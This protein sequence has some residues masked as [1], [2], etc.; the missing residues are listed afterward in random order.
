MLIRKILFLGLGHYAGH[1][2]LP[3][4]GEDQ[5]VVE[6]NKDRSNKIFSISRKKILQSLFSQF[7]NLSLKN[8]AVAF[9][10]DE[11][12]RIFTIHLADKADSI[13]NHKQVELDPDLF[14]I[15][16]AD[17]DEIQLSLSCGL[18]FNKLSSDNF[19]IHLLLTL[20][21]EPPR[22]F[23]AA[24]KIYM[25]PRTS[26]TLVGF[27][28]GSEASQ[29]CDGKYQRDEQQT[30]RSAVNLFQLVK[31]RLASTP[32]KNDENYEQYESSQLFKSSFYV[33]K[34]IPLNGELHPPT[35]NYSPFVKILNLLEERDSLIADWYQ[36][37]NL[38]LIHENSTLVNEYVF[39][40]G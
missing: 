22:N 21:E 30:T 33:K 32:V 5:Y 9:T 7:E 31:N 11:A 20:Q 25:A 3:D 36:I 4:V 19:F 40:P 26:I 17:E 2:G 6:Y 28:F 13:T 39:H 16:E 37:P 18:A 14:L 8:L 24:L 27:D 12:N 38:K 35:N 1:N 29:L 15:A 34:Q 23:S 10:Y